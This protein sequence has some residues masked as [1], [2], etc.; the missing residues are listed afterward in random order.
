LKD[1]KAEQAKCG[2]KTVSCCLL[3]VA[4]CLFLPSMGN[5]EPGTGD[6]VFSGFLT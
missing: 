5:G 2:I 4:G 6:M 3:Q 1:A